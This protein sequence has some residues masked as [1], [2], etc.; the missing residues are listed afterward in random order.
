MI[1]SNQQTYENDFYAWTLQSADLLRQKKF[2]ELD[3]EHLAEEIESMGKS[4][5][6]ELVN[7]LAILLSHLLKWQFQPE[8]RSNSWK[9]TIEEQRN[10]LLDLLKDSP[11]LKNDLESKKNQAYGSAVLR[12]ATETGMSKDKFPH[13]CPFTLPQCLDLEFS[14]D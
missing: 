3:I 12:A 10:Q 7:R 14:P 5:K 8:R 2:N 1:T 6:R 9:Y 11:S 13:S 4:D